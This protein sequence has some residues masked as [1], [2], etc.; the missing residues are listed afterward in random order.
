MH[1]RFACL[2]LLVLAPF[3][4]AAAGADPYGPIDGVKLNKPEDKVDVSSVKAPKDAIVLFDGKSLDGWTNRDGKAPAGFKLLDGGIMQAHGGD[5]IT[6]QKFDGTFKLHVEFRVPYM[7]KASGQGRGNS[8]VYLQG[9]YE[10]QVLDSY[11][12]V[13]KKDDCG[14]I[15]GVAA[16]LVNACKAPTVWQSYDITFQAPV[17]ENGKKK[18]P[19]LITVLHNG[20]KIHDNVKIT[21]DNT[22]SGMG[23][24]VCTPG[25]ILLQYHGDPV[26]YRNIWLVK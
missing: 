26:Q 5:I 18:S 12:L 8:G 6:K 22:T 14:A 24:D 1:Q 2:T 13:S 15:Y 10:I 16:P 9:R 20:V 11:G 23:G 21:S 7:G 3:A 25:P 19:A 17:C 4:L